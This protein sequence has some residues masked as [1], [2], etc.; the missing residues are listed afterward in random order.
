MRRPSLLGQGASKLNLATA[1]KMSEKKL[2]QGK[3]PMPSIKKPSNPFDL[4][5]HGSNLNSQRIEKEPEVRL[6]S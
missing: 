4:S 3:P 1:Q 5:L 2:H 6:P